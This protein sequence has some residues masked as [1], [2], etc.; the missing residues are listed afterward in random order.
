M[1]STLVL[2]D[3]LELIENIPVEQLSSVNPVWYW[4]DFQNP[5]EEEGRLL[6]TY[7]HFHPLAIE[8]CFHFLQRP[9]LDH[10][11]T[12]KFFVLHALNQDTLDAEEVDMFVGD[13]FVVSFHLTPLR[14]IKEVWNKIQRNQDR[15]TEGPSY[16]V[17]SVID[18]LVDYYFPAVHEIE[19]SLNELDSTMKER[20][21]RRLMDEVFDIRGDLIKLRRIVTSM[22]DLVYRILNSERLRQFQESHVYF[23]DVYDHLLRLSEIVDASREI[24]ADMR[25]SY[26][27]M[28][29]HRM[30]NIMVTLTIISSIFIPLTFIAGVYGMNFDYMPELKWKYG[31]FII[32]GIMLAVAGSLF[33][34]F[35]RKGW[36]DM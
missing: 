33:W 34:W 17:Y 21:S 30:N 14:E 26:I 19:D 11:E 3:K 5:T 23:T 12:Y 9:K 8:D 31:Y 10:Y 22:Q 1:I 16:I 6:D 4:V 35:R 29:S 18:K 36:F 15:W 13:H 7:F 28:T 2:T 32:L 25:D 20:F 27:S 24:T